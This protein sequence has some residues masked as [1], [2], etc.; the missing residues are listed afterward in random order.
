MPCFFALLALLWLPGTASSA[1]EQDDRATY[2]QALEFVR[3]GQFSRSKELQQQ[4]GDYPL[5]P[6]VEYHRLNN[7]IRQT[8]A[9]QIDSFRERHGDLP[10]TKL[11]YSRWLK[12]QG[13]RR[14]WRTLVERR[15][16][17]SNAELE[18]YFVRAQ[19]GIGEKTQALDAT[20]ALWSKPK[21]QPKACDPLFS[22]WRGTERFSQ[23]VI[24]QRFSGAMDANERVLARYLQRYLTGARRNTAKAFYELR[25]QPQRVTWRGAFAEDTA[26]NRE[27]ISYGIR[28]LSTRKPESAA[29]A[30]AAFSKTHTFLD[31]QRELIAAHVIVGLAQANRFP[32][33]E[34][35]NDIRSDYAV[36]GL[37][38]AAIAK[39]RW[40]EVVYWVSRLSPAQASEERARYWL[41][42][43]QSQL[44]EPS[45]FTEL[46]SQRSYYGFLAA[47]QQRSTTQLRAMPTRAF[48]A[49]HEAELLQIPGIA[50]AVELF[51]VGDTLNGRREWY[52]QLKRQDKETQHA[53]AYLARRLGKLFLTIQTA[54]GAQARD[55]LALRFPA[56][57]GPS[58]DDVALRHDIDSS[59]LRAITRQESAFQ[60]KAK[61]SAGALGL[62]QVMPATAK[63]AMRR[64]NL[65]RHLG[66]GSGQVIEHDLVIPE[67]NIEIGSYHLGWLL[68][69]YDNLRP[70]AIAAYNAGESRV[71]RWLR[72][73][74]SVPID[75]WIETI[76]FRE[77]R[78]YV[79]NV[80]AFQV[81][82]Q[83]L[84][85]RPVP[86]LQ[87]NE[88]VTPG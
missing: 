77:T 66:A 21:S 25:S 62:M 24:W 17:T 10:V 11:L 86:I 41:A 18:C 69:R 67:R 64:G 44:G 61:S 19:Y 34:Q 2:R 32:E 5:A 63:L 1:S 13:K 47:A 87:D 12:D 73:S 39:Q 88:W 45:S 49:E 35:R 59:L 8:S 75:V 68:K 50:R 57:Y 52:Q 53:M 72:R 76:P 70:L 78:N 28:R 37:V 46:A 4:L 6:Y 3:K 33:P 80:L 40:T 84:E 31:T 36:E 7:S 23:G 56:A 22:V 20:T 65:A 16:D 26:E 54:N 85:Q 83:G 9:S 48:T 42:R 82:Y 29:A 81:V 51:A 79:Q 43:A 30:W 58:F 14:N 74:P 55:D 15:Y 27:A 38:N 71:D 60:V